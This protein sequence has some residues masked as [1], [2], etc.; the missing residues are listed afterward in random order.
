MATSTGW[1]YSDWSDPDLYSWG[2][3]E[4]QHR[5]ALH[6]KELDDSIRTGTYG[7]GT[8]HVDKTIIMQDLTELRRIFEEMRAYGLA[9]DGSHYPTL[10]RGRALS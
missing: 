7:Q 6:I 5:L 10:T 3:R 4:C 9:P 1:L 2:S 8:Y